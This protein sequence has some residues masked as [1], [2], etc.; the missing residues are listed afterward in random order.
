MN[1]IYFIYAN[2]YIISWLIQ[3]S[4]NPWEIGKSFPQTI[5]FLSI[6]CAFTQVSSNLFRFHSCGFLSFLVLYV[7]LMRNSLWVVLKFR[8]KDGSFLFS[9]EREKTLFVLDL[10]DKDKRKKKKRNTQF[11][12]IS[13][14][15]ILVP[16]A[17]CKVQLTF[18][19]DWLVGASSDLLLYS[20]WQE[21]LIE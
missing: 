11:F 3:K 12:D 8:V 13:F 17:L 16:F 6:S 2:K 5:I 1:D 9:R 4:P 10:S 14:I 21:P 20:V 19:E 7:W 15:Y 18:P